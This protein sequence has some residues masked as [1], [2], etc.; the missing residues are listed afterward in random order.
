ME[1][2]YDIVQHIYDVHDISLIFL[3]FDWRNFGK[4]TLQIIQMIWFLFWFHII[5]Y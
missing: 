2:S 1:I 4:Y 3:Q 5:W